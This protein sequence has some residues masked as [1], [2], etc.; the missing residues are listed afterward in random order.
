M[1]PH[2]MSLFLTTNN[3]E[4]LALLEGYL[5]GPGTALALQGGMLDTCYS[6]LFCVE[7]RLNAEW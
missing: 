6:L 3:Q 7:Q 1:W 5:S 2:M 4:F